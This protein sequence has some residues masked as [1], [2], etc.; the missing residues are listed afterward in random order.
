MTHDKKRL[1]IQRSFSPMSLQEPEKSTQ[2][3]VTLEK[4]VLHEGK[5]LL[6]AFLDENHARLQ[7]DKTESSALKKSTPSVWIFGLMHSTPRV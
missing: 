3:D 4:V 6:S 1:D 2:L 5:E 7:S